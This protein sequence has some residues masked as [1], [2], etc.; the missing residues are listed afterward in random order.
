MADIVTIG[1]A[2]RDVFVRSKDVKVV[3][4]TSFT[5]G[6]GLAMP[7]GSKIALDE[8]HFT[9]G[10]GSVN[11]AVTFAQQGFRVA[12][13]IVVGTDARGEEIKDFLKEKR[14]SS[15]LVFEDSADTTA[16][17]V[18]VSAGKQ[19]RTILEYEGVKWKLGE[20]KIPWTK[21]KK[22]KWFYITH[23]GGKSAKLIPDILAFAKKND[24]KVAWNPGRT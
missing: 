19:G 8:L 2:T 6:K 24:I 13:M 3:K 18:I 17:S 7:L 15:E 1:S 4:E 14:I 11:P 10:G 16:Y 22:T 9:I 21:L 12:P 20:K 5:T 23:L